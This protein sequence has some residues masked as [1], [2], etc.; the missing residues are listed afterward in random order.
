MGFGTARNFEK[1][2]R[3]SLIIRWFAVWI[4]FDSTSRNKVNTPS[5]N[6]RLVVIFPRLLTGNNGRSP[7]FSETR[8]LRK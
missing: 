7:K 8:I 6:G 1:N 5:S 4:P 3:R 2:E